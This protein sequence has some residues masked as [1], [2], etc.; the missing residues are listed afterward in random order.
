MWWR[1]TVSQTELG[2][3]LWELCCKL[4]EDF[5]ANLRPKLQA[6]GL[7]HDPAKDRMFNLEAMQLHLWI[8]SLAL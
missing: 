1:R 5:S 2:Q 6:K 7:L 8:I 3:G 4:A